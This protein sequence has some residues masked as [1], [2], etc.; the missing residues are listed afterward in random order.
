MVLLGALAATDTLPVSAADLKQVIR[1]K[2]NPRFVE[3][4]LMAFE[5]G[6]AAARNPENWHRRPAA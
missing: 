2:T 4:N 6:A 5:M 1:D 3:A